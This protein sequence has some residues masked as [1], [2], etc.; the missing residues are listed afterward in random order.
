MSNYLSIEKIKRKTKLNIPWAPLIALICFLLGKIMSRYG[1]ALEKYY[2]S[3][4][5]K[6]II[7]YISQITGVFSFSLAEIIF[8]G[9]VISL[10]IILVFLIYKLI[11]GNFFLYLFKILNYLCILYIMFMAM[12]GFNYNRISIGTMLDLQV[13]PASIEELYRLNQAIIEKANTLRE[14]VEENLDGIMHLQEGHKDVFLRADQGYESLGK[15]L[16][17]LSGN[18]GKP[19]PIALSNLMLYTGISGIYFPF[20]AEAN[21]NVDIPHMILP[22]TTLHEMAHQRGFASEDEANYIAYLT[23]SA[24]PDVDFQYSGTVLALIHSM[25]ALY[26]QDAKLATTLR[27]TYSE[28]LNRDFKYYSA[29]WKAY[30]GK[31]NETSNKINNTYLKSNGQK[32]GIKSYGKMVDLL[33]AHFKKH[34]EI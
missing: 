32:D 14:E 24:H 6:T 9:H 26:A 2:S 11:K 16:K 5:N 7:Q 13:Q 20:T 29:F 3:T 8:V 22:A 15:T 1:Y 23:A 27:S 18:Y 19:K 4:I 10:P 21:V 31:A 25:N 12:W 33:L 30:E 17:V 28:G 34:G